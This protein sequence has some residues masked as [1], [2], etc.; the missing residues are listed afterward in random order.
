MNSWT[1]FLQICFYHIFSNQLESVLFPKPLLIIFSQIFMLQ[2][3]SKVILPHQF[4]ITFLNFL[5]ILTFLNVFPFL[6]HSPAS[7]PQISY[8]CVLGPYTDHFQI[9]F[10]NFLQILT[11]FKIRHDLSLICTNKIGIISIKKILFLTIWVWICMRS[12]SQKKKQILNLN[13]FCRNSI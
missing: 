7:F 5:Q 12:L 8:Y 9:T 1:H 13:V 2:V 11:F 4:Q 6:S 10:L 3:L